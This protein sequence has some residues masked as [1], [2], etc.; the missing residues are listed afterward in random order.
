[1]SMGFKKKR[2]NGSEFALLLKFFL[3]EYQNNVNGFSAQQLSPR[4][5]IRDAHL[6]KS[7]IWRS[8]IE[9]PN[10]PLKKKAMRPPPHQID[11]HAPK[12]T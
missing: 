6:L 7:K 1:M 5:Y 10:T 2:I 3:R 9:L 12:S 4:S 11:R 8:D